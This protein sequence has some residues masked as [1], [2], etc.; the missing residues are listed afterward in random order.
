[1]AKRRK[2][3]GR[4]AGPEHKARRSKGGAALRPKKERRRLRSA[5]RRPT[6]SRPSALDRAQQLV[7]RAF[8]S[9]D[10]DRR[11]ALAQQALELSADCADAYA[12]LAQ[13]VDDPR[14]ALLLLEQGLAASERLL[15]PIGFAESAAELWNSRRGRPY[16]RCRL[17]LGECLWTLGR[18]DEAVDH[19]L[20]LLR[21]DRADHQGVRYVLA[22]HLLELGRDDEFDRLI[23]DYDEPTAFFL[24]SRVLRE[25]RRT[26]DSPAARKLLSRARAVNRQIVGQLLH[27]TSRSDEHES[28]A[29]GPIGEALLYAMDFGGG[30]KQTPGAITWLRRVLEDESRR[31]QKPPTGPTLAVKKQL[32]RLKQSYGTVW[33]AAVGRVP[34]WMRDGESMVRPWSILIVNHSE[35]EIVGQ[36]L[37]GREPTPQALFDQL[38]CAMRKPKA[39]KSHRPSEIQVHED[40]L[41]RAVQPHLEEIGVDCIFRAE[42]EEA[43]YLVEEM[44]KLMHPEEQPA[45][46]VESTAFSSAQGAGLYAAAAEYFRRRPWQKLPASA[47]IQIDS[48]QLREFGAGRWYAAVLGQAAQTLGLALYDDPRQIEILCGACCSETLGN[49]ATTISL[50]F[51]E[52]FEVPI[53]DLL[54]AEQHH[55]PLASP[56]AWPLVVC[57][58]GGATLRPIESWERQL[59]EGCLRT[60]PDFVEQF[61]CGEGPAAVT[62]GPVPP[63]NLK[64]SLAWVEPH[65]D[66]S[67]SGGCG[68]ECNHRCEG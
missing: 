63:A 45:A 61:P 11:I 64:F 60:I 23:A 21:L 14:Q 67:Q 40:P 8:R 55:W 42:L 39:G 58:K 1:V 30:W 38:S 4:S 50:L 32:A 18:R 46:L 44:H 20:A 37:A 36:Q 28:V 33:Q 48:L 41:W 49:D 12:I 24:F 54:A 3:S 56:E 66:E 31:A 59:L 16:L 6:R 65:L 15:G 10:I 51:S 19:L 2:P 9:S 17:S 57:A 25:Y 62:L 53:A 68:D 47:V 27:G 7:A 29:A 43:D 13:L 5:G 34:A 35:H 52:N 26:G 22:A